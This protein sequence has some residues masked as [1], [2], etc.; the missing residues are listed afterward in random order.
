MLLVTK[1]AHGEVVTGN[2]LQLDGSGETLVLLGI[3]VLESDLEVDGLPE[4]RRLDFV[5]LF[6]TMFNLTFSRRN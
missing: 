5:G 2:V 6:P 1:D 4:L 3:V